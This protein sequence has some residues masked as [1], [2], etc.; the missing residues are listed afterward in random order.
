MK[1]SKLKQILNIV[2]RYPI[3]L[4]LTIVAYVFIFILSL[5]SIVLC[6][7][8]KLTDHSMRDAVVYYVTRE[9]SITMT[10]SVIVSLYIFIR[11]F[12]KSLQHHV[13][14]IL[15]IGCFMDIVGVLTSMRVTTLIENQLLFLL[16]TSMIAY[17]GIASGLYSNIKIFQ[18][19]LIEKSSGSD[20]G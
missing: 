12:K 20:L 10:I 17:V 6:Y 5:D 19:A 13:K 16:T 14:V 3:T 15:A 11:F 9:L 7:N 1:D 8:A 18:K 4:I 2:F